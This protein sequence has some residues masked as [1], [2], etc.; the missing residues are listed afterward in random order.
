MLMVAYC[1]WLIIA[2]VDIDKSQF[3]LGQAATTIFR[4]ARKSHIVI[5]PKYE[6]RQRK[7]QW[8]NNLALRRIMKELLAF[9]G[10]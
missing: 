4:K 7:Q 9:I 5:S 2:V 1:G 3:L 8:W 6:N 10:E